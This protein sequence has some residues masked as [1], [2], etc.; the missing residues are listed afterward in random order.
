MALTNSCKRLAVG[1]DK[2]DRLTDLPFNVLHQI[3]KHM[4]IEDAARMSVFSRKW[5]YVWA[6]NP[7]LVFGTHFCRKRKLSDTIEII[8][9]I[10]LQ[11]QGAIK[12]FLLGVPKIDSS[13]HPVVDEWLLLLSRNGLVD[14]TLQN[15]N[16]VNASYEL[17]SYVYGV[18]LER[19]YLSNCIFRPPC[20]FRGFH[21]LKKLSLK[22]VTFE[23][24]IAT[25]SLWMPNLEKLHFLECSGLRFLNIYA[26]ELLHL[27]FHDCGTDT[28]KLGPF[29]DCRKLRV[30][31]ILSQEEVSQNR[32]DKAIKLTS[33][34]SSWHDVSHL[35][36]DRCFLKFFASG[37]EE[38]RLPMSLNR[39]RFIY[40]H[41]YNFDGEDLIFPLL[42]I[43]RSSP[44][45]EEL[46]FHMHRRKKGDM[47]VD[48]N[49]PEGLN[50]LQKLKITG[51]RGSRNE[52]SFARFIL[53]SAPLLRKAIFLVRRSVKERR[54]LKIST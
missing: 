4:S 36:L 41:D 10:L 43:L 27:F 49:L 33:L 50:N 32:Q 54:S 40:F 53:T 7:R 25:S 45:L 9:S 16:N 52:L 14:L 26:P 22:R 44:N 17:P 8:S 46:N 20:S 42:C 5:R 31:G 48:V 12:K 1:G 38:E 13:R 15:P 47:K 11:H 34:L 21:K 23:L 30:V 6:T 18:E 35:F 51:F 3:Q 19:L 24:D 28:I 2:L 37:S 29:M 39:L